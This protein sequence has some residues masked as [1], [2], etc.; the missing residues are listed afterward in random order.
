MNMQTIK[1]IGIIM[2]A[3]LV[4]GAAMAQDTAGP[5]KGTIVPYLAPDRVD[6]LPPFYSNLGN[7]TCTGCNYDTFTGNLV[8]GPMSCLGGQNV[9][10]RFIPTRSGQV[11]RVQL[12]VTAWEQKCGPT[13]LQFRVAIYDDGCSGP[14]TLLSSKDAL[15]VS[16]PC[17]LTTVNYGTTGPTLAA[18]QVYWLAAEVPRMSDA[19]LAWWESYVEF[20]ARTSGSDPTYTLTSFGPNQG[21]FAVY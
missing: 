9:A 16:A 8:L 3:T 21:A 11:R 10:H 7:P 5:F 4:C 19:V 13:P 17:L 14:G 20:F 2:F 12:A 6:A 18:G 1:K 15:A